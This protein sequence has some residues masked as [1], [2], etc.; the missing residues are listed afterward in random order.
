[1]RAAAVPG[2]ELLRIAAELGEPVP[3]SPSRPVLQEL[4][5]LAA[6]DAPPR[7]LSAVHG[8]GSFPFHTDAAHHRQPPRWVVMHCIDPGPA[9]RPTLLAD[10]ARL[11]LTDRQWRA[12]ER[13]VCWVRSGGRGFLAAIVG[14]RD[15]RTMIRYDGGCMAPADPSFAGAAEL[16]RD[17]VSAAPHVRLEW[18]RDDLVIFDNW[19]ILHARGGASRADSGVR[20]LQ[21]VLVR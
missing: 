10:A 17:A 19:R 18:Q 2:E 20:C 7:S 4:T 8:V 9:H 15:G 21:R 3:A 11:S 13:A 5:P 6:G 16:F 14:H 1:M 12:L